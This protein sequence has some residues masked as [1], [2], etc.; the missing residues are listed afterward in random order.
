[1]KRFF[2]LVALCAM[3]V[4]PA[5]AQFARLD[6]YPALQPELE[7]AFADK[8]G[9]HFTNVVKSASGQYFGQMSADSNMY[10]YG[11]FYTDQDGEIYGLFRR[12]FIMGIRKNNTMALVGTMDHYIAYDLKTGEAL[13]IMLGGEKYLVDAENK[14][15][16]AFLRITYANGDAYVG[17]VTAGRPNGWGVYYYADGNYYLGRY[18]AGK[19]VG[20]GATFTQD[21]RIILHNWDEAGQ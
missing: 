21:N 13:Y 7:A 19:T 1:M 6:R 9:Q 10:G 14:A 15:Q 20:R 18:Q 3:A 17:E 12:G 4:A 16:W 5:C 11:T 2:L 8:V